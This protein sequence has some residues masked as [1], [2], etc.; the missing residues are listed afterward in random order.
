MADSFEAAMLPIEIGSSGGI[1]N[2]TK[3]DLVDPLEDVSEGEESEEES[4]AAS[5]TLGEE[6]SDCTPGA[7]QNA[8]EDDTTVQSNTSD[9]VYDRAVVKHSQGVKRCSFSSLFA[10]NRLPTMG[11]KLEQFD[12]VDA[13]IQIE[14]EDVQDT[15]FPWKWC[16]VGILVGDSQEN[17]PSNK[18]WSL[19]RFELPSITII[20]DRSFFNLSVQ[21]HK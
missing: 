20:V 1:P 19:G 15:G 18:L 16:L 7:R 12:K 17:W 10:G 5:R 4:E 2:E 6:D 14:A 13:P 8:Q 3:A 9:S 21:T 11:S